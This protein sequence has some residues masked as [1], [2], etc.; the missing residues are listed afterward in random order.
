MTRRTPA[1]LARLRASDPVDPARIAELADAPWADELLARITTTDPA[2]DRQPRSVP[3]GPRAT[4]TGR[5][6]RWRPV[7]VA[8][9]V[10]AI[11][12]GAAVA[13][14]NGSLPAVFGGHV[15]PQSGGLPRY[16]RVV[17]STL[18]HPIHVAT[19][20]DT[21]DLW[22]GQASNG[23]HLVDIAT[24]P[25]SSRGT[26]GPSEF[27]GMC[28]PTAAG[29]SVSVCLVRHPSDTTVV[30][31]RAD[32]PVRS[33]EL[34]TSTDTIPGTVGGGYFLIPASVTIRQLMTARVVGRDGDGRVVTVLPA[35]PGAR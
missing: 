2:S 5:P 31:G 14:L 6:V 10:L 21:F 23:K 11:G 8:A 7:V 13:A 12:A 17:P 15:P 22:T 33:V 4:E 29:A 27:I 35:V 26:A 16:L 25:S 34:Q 32:L 18:D 19:P 1:T 3:D 20:R 24:R 30:A 9:A 28:P